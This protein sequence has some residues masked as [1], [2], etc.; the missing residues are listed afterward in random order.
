MNIIPLKTTFIVL[1]LS[2]II[3]FIY[4]FS[5]FFLKTDLKI[6]ILSN[7][8][9]IIAITV[10]INQYRIKFKDFFLFSEIWKKEFWIK[11][12]KY[13]FFIFLFILLFILFFVLMGL[14]IYY[15][16]IEYYGKILLEMEKGS[17]IEKISLNYVIF[18]LAI[19]VGPIIEEIIFRRF[20]FYS[21]REKKSFM[22]AMLISNTIFT[23]L[24]FR[25][26]L[27]IFCIGFFLTYIFEKEKNIS[28]NI[29][30]H[31]TINL[32]KGIL[33]IFYF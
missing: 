33:Q 10:V 26:F 9:F 5:I 24:H 4:P 11:Y 29:I 16:N 3:I 23:F 32:I 25:N 21:L 22:C 19:F 13:L 8:Y 15:F 1:F 28:L 7:L 20:L 31:I 17:V 14:I 2:L 12:F 6:P 27:Y 18:F 30:I